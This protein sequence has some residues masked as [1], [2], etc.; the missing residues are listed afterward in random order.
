MVE[1]I[2]GLR[3]GG[4][5]ELREKAKSEI[6][7]PSNSRRQNPKPAQDHFV[8]GRG[9]RASGA[10]PQSSLASYAP[11]NSKSSALLLLKPKR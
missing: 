9:L 1:G 5:A 7:K 11:G 10:A 4:C 8:W 3:F 2:Q 6:P